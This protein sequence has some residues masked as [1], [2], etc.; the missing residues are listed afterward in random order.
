L[1]LAVAVRRN[2]IQNVGERARQSASFGIFR[3]PMRPHGGAS[4]QALMECRW[5]ARCN[6]PGIMMHVLR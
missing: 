5:S 3:A 2:P 1:F 4:A 6:S